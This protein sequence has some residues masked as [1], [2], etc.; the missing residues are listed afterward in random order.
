MIHHPVLI[1]G[2]WCEANFPVSSFKA[3]NPNTGK[4]LA[5]SFPV[6]SF[7]DIDEQLQS[8]R[9]STSLIEQ[10]SPKIRAEFLRLLANKILD[11]KETL[12][13]TA[14]DET[15][16]N[17]E[18]RLAMV[19][20][21]GMIN[22]LNKAAEYC[23]NRTWSDITMDT[24]QNI[25]SH[26]SK[27]PGSV[28]IFGPSGS[29][30]LFNACGGINFA[31]AIA[32]GN[33]IIAKGSPNHPMTSLKLA[34]IIHSAATELCLPPGLFQ[35]FHHTTFDLGY[36]LA[37]HPMIGALSFT[38]SFRSG[39]AL[40][41]NADRAGNPVFLEMAGSNPVFLLAGAVATKKEQLAT[42]LTKAILNNNGQLCTKPGPVFMVENKNSSQ[43]IKLVVEAFAKESSKPMLTDVMARNLDTIIT[44][45]MRMGARKLTKKEFY[46]PTPFMYP[47]T[48]L[49]LDIKSYLK[50]SRQFQEEA[51][52]P[53]AIFV[54]L[55]DSKQFEQVTKSLE[56][57]LSC[58]IFAENTEEDNLVYGKIAPEIRRKTGRLIHDKLP[59]KIPMTSA[60]VQGGPFPSTGN[61]GYTSIGLPSS[62]KRFSVIHC[63]EGADSSRLP[64][65]LRST[66]PGN[67]T[68]R[69]IDGVLTDK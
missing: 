67:G 55:E 66:P 19:E 53:I 36:R 61:P 51:F 56:G 18:E 65:D 29:P 40:K 6:S 31:A 24:E 34:Q 33:S 12:C 32:A 4:Q 68:M 44:H 39:L 7:L 35:F 38:G 46:G 45:F 23:F 13:E 21:P 25:C 2:V 22:Q 47:N 16:I 28:V 62:I 30:F 63:Y 17:K 42:D 57:C 43:L 8:Q 49:V 48:V 5:E 9:T 1:N 3:V 54:T 27:M 64:D 14:F 20:I 11:Q 60:M 69:L 41:E 26:R 50:F 52:G 59:D 58:S 15:A 37:A 10:V